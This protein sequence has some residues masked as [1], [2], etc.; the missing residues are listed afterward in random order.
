VL[1]VRNPEVVKHDVGVEKGCS[2]G[3]RNRI[4][5]NFGISAFQSSGNRRVKKLD[6]RTPKIAKPEI[7]FRKRSWS[8]LVV[9]Y[10]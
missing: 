6:I 9:T 2:H 5:W 1:G 7:P 10:R 4:D 8:Y 3:G